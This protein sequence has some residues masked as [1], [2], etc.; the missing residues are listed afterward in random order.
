MYVSMNVC[1]CGARMDVRG[2]IESGFIPQPAAI[3]S[4]SDAG[5]LQA[6]LS[7][8]LEAYFE[9][10]V[11]AQQHEGALWVRIFIQVIFKTYIA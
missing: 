3:V 9:H 8:Q 5:S 2:L 1:M 11:F 7:R 10:H 6:S 4:I